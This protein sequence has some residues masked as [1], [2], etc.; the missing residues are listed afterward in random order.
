MAMGKKK[1][2]NRGA[3]KPICS[4]SD[5]ELHEFES[6]I[7]D[8]MSVY[9]LDEITAKIMSDG[10]DIDYY[11]CADDNGYGTNIDIED[12]FGLIQV[13]MRMLGI[14]SV[15]CKL[16]GKTVKFKYKFAAA[17]ANNIPCNVLADVSLAAEI[18]NTLL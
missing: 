11:K 5:N 13:Y 1:K 6:L 12:M 3:A 9:N 18:K 4:E 10:I 16:Y 7:C 8:C 15:H 17:P 14:K 2:R